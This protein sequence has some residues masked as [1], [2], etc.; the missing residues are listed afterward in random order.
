MLAVARAKEEG[1]DDFMLIHDSFGTHCASTGRFGSIIRES[2]LEMYSN[3]DVIHD[4]YLELRTQLLPE[5]VEDLPLPPAKGNLVLA[6]SLES[7]YS[8]A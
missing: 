4:L 3:S 1:I 2:M 5:E 7:R 6:D 8:F